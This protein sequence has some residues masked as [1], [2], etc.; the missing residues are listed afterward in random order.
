ME[1]AAYRDILSVNPTEMTLASMNYIDLPRSRTGIVEKAMNPDRGQAPA[2]FV[3]LFGTGSYSLRG[4]AA[5][6]L[7]RMALGI[8]IAIIASFTVVSSPISLISIV[9]L[10]AMTIA[11]ILLRPAC[12]AIS[13]FSILGACGGLISATCAVGL[14]AVS[15]LLIA[16]GA[17]RTS[18]DSRIYSL[19]KMRAA[20][21]RSECLNSY[22]AFS[23]I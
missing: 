11:G 2:L 5:L 7:T 15:L 13:V 22:K 17:G 20:R 9:M 6:M 10:S 16:A 12:V 3:A 23:H 19:A 4:D 18:I 14:I 21:R 8:F 1:R